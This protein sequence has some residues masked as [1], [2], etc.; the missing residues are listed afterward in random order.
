MNYKIKLLTPSEI[1]STPS[2]KPFGIFDPIELE[3]YFI[4]TFEKTTQ[5][6]TETTEAIIEKFVRVDTKITQVLTN[7]QGSFVSRTDRY[8]HHTFPFAVWQAAVKGV[9]L[10][11][12]QPI[13]DETVLNQICSQFGVKLV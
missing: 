12:G 1:A 8:T 4:N 2:A 9:D 10:D 13:L 3:V 5:E 7:E 11:T 6:A